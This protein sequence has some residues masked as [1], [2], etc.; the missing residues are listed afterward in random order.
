ML[1]RALIVGVYIGDRSRQSAKR[2]WQSLLESLPSRR[3]LL[4]RLLGG[5]LAGYSWQATSIRGQGN[6][7]D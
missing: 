6:R 7:Q 3:H 5:I 1:T 4:H 2:L